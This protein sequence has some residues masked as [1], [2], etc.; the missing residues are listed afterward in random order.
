M[1]TISEPQP[2]TTNITVDSNASCNGIADG[3][4]TVVAN[5]GTVAVDYSYLWDDPSAQN[6][7]SATN[8]AAG[9]Y[10][11]TVTDDNGC[12]TNDNVTISEPDQL[13]AI[14]LLVNHVSCNGLSDGSAT[15]IGVGG[16]VAADYTYLWDDPTAQATATA[17]NLAAGTYTITITDDNGCSADSTIDITQPNAL[18][19]TH[20][21]DAQVSCF[22]LSDG[23]A[24]VTPS[25]GTNPY[26]YLWD[27]PAAQ[28]T[29]TATGLA[30]GTYNCTITDNGAKSWNLNYNEDFN[31][32]IGAEWDDNSTYVFRGETISGRFANNDDVTLNLSSLPAHDSIRIVCDLYIFDSWDGNNTSNGPDFWTISTDNDTIIHTTFSN[33]DLLN[34][35]GALPQSYPGDYTQNNP[36]KTFKCCGK[37]TI[38][39]YERF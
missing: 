8:L 33:H 22:G 12:N 7:A 26:T 16:T 36:G 27:D 19:A 31:A 39:R 9:S 15:S 38:C 2:I 11:V 1:L 3:G 28:T 14:P 17:T 4:V 6:T 35:F 34:P 30:A 29:P 23:Q 37:F 20:T 5:G 13:F 32:A 18:T 10:S 24:T 21:I 25:G